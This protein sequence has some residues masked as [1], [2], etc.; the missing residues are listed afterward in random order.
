MKREHHYLGERETSGRIIEQMSKDRSDQ[1]TY[2]VVLTAE[3]GDPLLDFPFRSIQPIE[4]GDDIFC[5]LP[6]YPVLVL[7]PCYRSQ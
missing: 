1:L 5:P 6:S 3:D 7:M 4:E 2:R